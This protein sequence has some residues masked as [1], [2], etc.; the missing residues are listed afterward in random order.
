MIFVTVGTELPFDRLVRAVDAWARQRGRRDVFAQVGAGGWRPEWVESSE[1]LNP[2]EFT[3][4]FLDAHL[5]VGHAGMGTI[6]SALRYG[7]PFVVMPRLASL[8][9]QRN[10]HQLATARH[11]AELKKVKV[12]YSPEELTELLDRAEELAVDQTIGPYA[13]ERLRASI[14]D[15][16][17]QSAELPAATPPSPAA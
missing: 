2:P 8:G 13:E 10:D 9:E 5:V 7:K 16:I 12:A 11:L 4:K 1:F 3:R 14:R 17:W 15:F 6:L